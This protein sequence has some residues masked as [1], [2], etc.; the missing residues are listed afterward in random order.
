MPT[1]TPTPIAQEVR[2]L[3][4]DPESSPNE[5]EAGVNPLER[6]TLLRSVLDDRAGVISLTALARCAADPDIHH[7]ALNVDIVRLR[8]LGVIVFERYGQVVVP[9]FQFTRTGELRAVVAA[10]NHIL[11][12]P[13]SPWFAGLWWYAHQ[14]GINQG[15][16]KMPRMIDLLAVPYEIGLVLE[17]AHEHAGRH[18]RG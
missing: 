13:R 14:P 3:L 17:R 15:G 5:R 11:G 18:G 4:C 10:V 16:D 9:A 8:E 2:D 1:I 7:A 6:A 12:V